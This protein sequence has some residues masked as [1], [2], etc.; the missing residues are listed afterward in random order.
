VAYPDLGSALSLHQ[1]QCF[2]QVKVGLAKLRTNPTKRQ[3]YRLLESAMRVLALGCVSLIAFAITAAPSK[4]PF[5]PDGKPTS[6]ESSLPPGWTTASPR[7]EIR[8]IFSF[9]SKGGPKS[10]GALVI[11]S[12][13]REGLHGW[14]AK[15][16]PVTGDRYYRFHAVRKIHNVAAPR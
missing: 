15:S 11:A 5:T 6:T 13:E 9:H 14:F 16:F 3:R 12:D 7:D 2:W 8:P 1:F 4:V 10:D